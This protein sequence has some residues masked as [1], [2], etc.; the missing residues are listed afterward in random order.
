VTPPAAPSGNEP[1]PAGETPRPNLRKVPVELLAP[2]GWL[3]G[4]IHVPVHQTLLEFLT[5]TPRLLKLTRVRLPQEPD[6]R[7]FV[8]LRRDLIALVAPSFSEELERPR[9][10]GYTALRPVACLLPHCVVRG[11]LAV[12]LNMRLSDHLQQQAPLLAL[13]HCLLTPYGAT[14]KSPEARAFPTLIVNLDAV[15]GISD[16]LRDC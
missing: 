6:P 10:A 2:M 7:P 13:Q 12:Q 16:E 11:S 8:A 14:A 4:L 5:L 9:D 1:H 15:L 3:S